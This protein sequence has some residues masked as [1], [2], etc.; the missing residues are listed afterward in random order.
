VPAFV[1]ASWSDQGLHTRGTFEGFKKISS[2]RKWLDA[3]GGKKWGYYYSPESL[4]RQQAF[5]DQFLK[6][7]DTGVSG[8]PVVSYEVR[9]H[10][11]ASAR[12]SADGWPLPGTSYERL[13][14]DAGHGSLRRDP[15]AAR[16]S[17]SYD[18]E[19]AGRGRGRFD[20]HL[21][22]PRAPG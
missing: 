16:A 14:L 5:F 4:R 15:P 19:R 11:G 20:S 7:A 18:S 17:V 8:W 12:R 13:F 2:P 10:P 3:H 6:G 21:L 22:I 9:G 1:V